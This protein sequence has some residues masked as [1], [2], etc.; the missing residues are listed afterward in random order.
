MLELFDLA[1]STVVRGEDLEGYFLMILMT[2]IRR[3]FC[4]SLLV[5][6]LL[7][8]LNVQPTI[9]MIRLVSW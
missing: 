6:D 7:S 8:I 1:C 5:M 9:I 4:H 3:C 2:M